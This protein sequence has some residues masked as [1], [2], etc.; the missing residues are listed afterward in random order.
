MESITFRKATR[1]DLDGIVRLLVDD[2][3]GRTREVCS[4]P[5]DARYTSAFK[6]ID[7]DPNQLLAVVVDPAA[8]TDEVA[9]CMQ[10]TFIPG[11]SRTGMWR[12]QIENVRVAAHLRGGGVG[13]RFFEWA[14]ERCRERGCGLVQ[15]TSDKAR[16][17][18]LRFYV[19]LGF[20]ASHEGFKLSLKA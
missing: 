5:P 1:D 2:P 11:L 7:C 15:L 19:S 18:A 20:E 4:D 8:E 13:R 12:G 9:G 3:I 16:P 10:L 6:A 17:D 14:I